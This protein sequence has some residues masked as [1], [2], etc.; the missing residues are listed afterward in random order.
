VL[1]SRVV[2]SELAFDVVLEL[3]V[4]CERPLAL[5]GDSPGATWTERR[6]YVEQV[7]AELRQFGLAQGDDVHPDLVA[8]LSVL[9]RPQ[10]EVYGIYAVEGQPVSMIMA[11]SVGR[12]GVFACL[13]DSRLLLEPVHPYSLH[14][15]LLTVL[16]E[17]RPIR[18]K[19]FHFP[20]S[21]LRGTTRRQAVDYD[22]GFMHSSTVHSGQSDTEKDQAKRLLAIPRTG[23]GQFFAACRDDTGRRHR[24]EFPVNCFDTAQGCYLTEQHRGTGGEQWMRITPGDTKALAATV[25]QAAVALRP[26]RM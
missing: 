7:V 20:V 24:G 18:S 4:G 5:A 12:D 6:R 16:P 2:I 15:P 3:A 14:E 25:Q 21:A 17:L 10:R 9:A 23:G 11:G 26:G 22:S 19:S 13:R 8:A 1:R